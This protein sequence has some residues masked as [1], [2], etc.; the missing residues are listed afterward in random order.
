MRFRLYGFRWVM[1][2]LYALLLLLLW[3]LGLAKQSD[4]G[5]CCFLLG[6]AFFTLSSQV[7]FIFGAGTRDLIKPIHR[8][9]RLIAPV[10]VA[11]LLMAFLAAG[12]IFSADELFE[13]KGS[14]FPLST[15]EAFIS[16]VAVVWL[17]WGVFFYI[18]TRE[19]PRYAVLRRLTFWV[20]GGSLAEMMA[21]IPSH[22]IVSRR[23]GCLVGLQTAMA[24]A[25]G[26]YVM[27]W[28]FGPG[29]VLLF[30]KPKRD[31]EA[32][33]ESKGQESVSKP[34]ATSFSLM[35]LLLIMIFVASSMAVLFD[36]APEFSLLLVL[37]SGMDLL[38][39][40]YQ[41]IRAW[42]RES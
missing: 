13:W 1:L 37:G 11:A 23:P 5:L 27:L 10:A 8:K 16:F 38:R 21:C 42:E 41:R 22:I 30:L 39:R 40:L 19:H 28:S 35:T 29:I 20:L 33:Q 17:A 24:V 2:V 32:Q 7:L 4:E 26:V 34:K 15:F 31:R 36:V 25:A 12:M 9:R 6:L 18:H 14:Q 3:M